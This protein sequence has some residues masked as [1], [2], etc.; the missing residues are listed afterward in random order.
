[1][2]VECVVGLY[3]GN[4][5]SLADMVGLFWNLCPIAGRMNSKKKLRE[6]IQKSSGSSMSSKIM[7]LTAA[8]PER[9][10]PTM[11]NLSFRGSDTKRM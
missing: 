6:E 3:S 10:A 11:A 8:I 1:M 7:P 5:T 4:L 9:V 2:S